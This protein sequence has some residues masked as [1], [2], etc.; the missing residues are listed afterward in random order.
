[1]TIKYPKLKKG[2]Y[3][4]EGID[5][6]FDT[7]G[8]VTSSTTSF[9]LSLILQENEF[10]IAQVDGDAGEFTGLKGIGVFKKN[11]KTFDL[12]VVTNSPANIMFILTPI[13]Y[14]KDKVVSL[15]GIDVE[16]NY[17][18]NPQLSITPSVSSI[19]LKWLHY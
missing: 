12:Y 19:T 17:T 15:E 9:K 7:N 3:Q 13:C 2:V 4:W 11:N 16:T 8:E 1:M 18:T 10:V 6:Y 5:R 14:K